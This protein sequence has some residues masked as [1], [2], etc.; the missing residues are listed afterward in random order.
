MVLTKILNG[1]L[2]LT[3]PLSGTVSHPWAS[4]CYRQPIYQVAVSNSTH[5]E[6]MKG[7]TKCRKWGGLG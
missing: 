1:L 3:T 2:D 6:D 4:T 5:Y 7:G